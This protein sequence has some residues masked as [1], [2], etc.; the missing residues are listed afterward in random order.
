[1]EERIGK[2]AERG[3]DSTWRAVRKEFLLA[4]PLCLCGKPAQMVHHVKAIADGGE[5]LDSLN[6]QAL[7]WSCHATTHRRSGVH[8]G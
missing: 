4:H 1:M 6:L 7:C 3:Y 5:R 8:H 2:P